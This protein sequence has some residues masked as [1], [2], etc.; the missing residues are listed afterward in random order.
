[1][2]VDGVGQHKR[3]VEYDADRGIGAEVVDVPFGVVGV[4]IV[5]LVGEEE[6]GVVVVS[7]ERNTVHFPEEEECLVDKQRDIDGCRGG[8]IRIEANG[9]PGYSFDEGILERS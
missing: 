5:A 3:I 1:M 6:D 8:R 2:H 9:V 7:A 4:G